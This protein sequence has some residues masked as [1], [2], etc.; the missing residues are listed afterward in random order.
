MTYRSALSVFRCNYLMK[1]LFIWSSADVVPA[2]LAD[3]IAAAG[4]KRNGCGFIYLII[5]YTLL[6]LCTLKT[7]DTATDRLI[8]DP[9]KICIDA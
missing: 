7:A 9:I 4:L 5:E 6:L 1:Y 2:R 3:T 8:A